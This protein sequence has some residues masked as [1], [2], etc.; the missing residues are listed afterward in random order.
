MSYI[1]TAIKLVPVILTLR[2]TIT[3]VRQ[4][5][6]AIVYIGETAQS[7]QEWWGSGSDSEEWQWVEAKGSF[8]LFQ[9]NS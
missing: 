4:V 9:A 1:L 2:T 7:I 5:S 3:T 6:S 8:E